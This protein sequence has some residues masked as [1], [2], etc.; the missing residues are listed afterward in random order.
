MD[1]GKRIIL[2]M[3]RDGKITEDEAISLLD[4]LKKENR[5]ENFEECKESFGKVFNQ[6]ADLATKAYEKAN[7]YV[8]NIDYEKINLKVNSFI[9]EIVNEFRTLR[10]TRF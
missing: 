9:D 4:S 1:E 7:D 6:I 10:R 5:S 8:S 2:Q 3:L